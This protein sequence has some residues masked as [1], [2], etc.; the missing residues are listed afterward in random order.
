MKRWAPGNGQGGGP[1][2]LPVAGI[3][4]IVDGPNAVESV[5]EASGPANPPL[6]TPAILPPRRPEGGSTFL[7]VKT[8]TCAW[9]QRTLEFLEALHQERGDFQIAVLDAGD[10]PDEFRQ[11]AAGTRRTTVPQVFLDGGFV[12]GWTELA[13]AAKSGRLDRY[14]DGEDWASPA[15][16][17]PWWRK[18]SKPASG[19]DRSGP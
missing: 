2:S 6:G 12:G 14:L 8:A 15:P 16:K 9:C 5:P 17:R 1:V 13:A 11:I 18:A 4:G 7:I 10:R 3:P 19:M